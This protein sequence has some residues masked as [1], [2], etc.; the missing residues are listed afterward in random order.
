MYKKT[1][2]CTIIFAN[3]GN[4]MYAGCEVDI[5]G[6]VGWQIIYSGNVTGYIDENGVERDD[7]EGCELGRVLII[8]YSKSVTC[9]EYSYSYS[10]YPGVVIMSNGISMAACI[11]GDMYDVNR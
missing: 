7:F 4:P 1:L 9:A 8:D 3:F 6:Y 11:D 10:Y 5:S 2:I